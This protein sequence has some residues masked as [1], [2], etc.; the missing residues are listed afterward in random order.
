MTLDTHIQQK[1]KKK[2]GKRHVDLSA[3]TLYYNMVI[4]ED[5]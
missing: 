2:A 1:K 5:E 4:L 3:I